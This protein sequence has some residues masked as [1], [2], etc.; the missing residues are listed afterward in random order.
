MFNSTMF[1]TLQICILYFQ[2]FFDTCVCN[3]YVPFIH[4][5][6]LE[7]IALFSR[8]QSPN[9]TEFHRIDELGA[10]RSRTVNLEVQKIGRYYVFIGK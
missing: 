10:V 7:E 2:T 1:G 3:A 8:D 6:F 5:H 4:L 9:G